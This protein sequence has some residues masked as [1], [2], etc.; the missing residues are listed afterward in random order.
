MT[1]LPIEPAIVVKDT[2]KPR[3]LAT[4]SQAKAFVEEELRRGRPPPWRDVHRRLS[5]VANAEDAVEAI[6][7]LRELLQLEDLLVPHY[8]TEHS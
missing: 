6:G 3:R 2:P 8:P 1:E 4:L 5:S 7:A